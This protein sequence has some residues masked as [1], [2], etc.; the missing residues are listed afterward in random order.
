[1]NMLILL[2]VVVTKNVPI[3]RF[4][5]D[6]EGF[7]NVCKHPKDKIMIQGQFILFKGN[8]H[9]HHKKLMVDN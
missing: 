9:H 2:N 1:M 6:M 8:V 4:F 7:F 5:L 3:L